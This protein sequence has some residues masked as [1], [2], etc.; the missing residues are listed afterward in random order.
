[1]TSLSLAARNYLAQDPELRAL[2]GRSQS[3]DT[4][5]FDTKPVG[6][7]IENT[8]RCMIVINESGTWTTRNEHN[9][10]RFPQLQVDIWADPTR[11]SD[12]SVQVYDASDKIERIA[13]VLD[14][15]LHLTDPGTVLGRPY[16]W[17]T[18]EQVLAKTG[19]V[20][21][22]CFH[23]DGPTISDVRETDGTLMGRL[24]YGVNVL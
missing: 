2:L 10:M 12:L 4:W 23:R 9:T 3:W 21:A 19:V 16:V 5:I 24:V 17:G 14:K 8:S 1:M 13:K 7:R 20:I 22:G 11:N 15:H 6:V 18:A